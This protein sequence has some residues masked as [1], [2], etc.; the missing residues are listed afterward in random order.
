MS[1][2][3]SP[4]LFQFCRK[5]EGFAKQESRKPRAVCSVIY[6]G[7]ATDTGEYE[8][9]GTQSHYAGLFRD[10]NIRRKDKDT[11]IAVCDETACKY[12]LP[13]DEA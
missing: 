1:K 5:G 3:S 8:R 6:S 7:H 10:E 4:Y 2:R 13:Y 9:T 11:G 12:H